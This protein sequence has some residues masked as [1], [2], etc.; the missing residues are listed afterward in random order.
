[1]IFSQSCKYVNLVADMTVDNGSFAVSELDT[2]GFSYCTLIVAFGNVPANTS[3][4]KVTESD[5]AGSGHADVTGLIVGTS[6]NTDG[7]TSTLP[8]AAAGDGDLVI[9]EIDL[10]G[11]K[12]Y[13]DMTITAGNG[14]GTVTECAVIAQL[15]RAKD[16]PNT[17]TERGAADILRV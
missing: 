14:A 10:R 17:A 1:M 11:R 6:T 3:A 2:A 7:T 4:L 16:F 9:F 15:W 13:L 8:T 5:T 12:R